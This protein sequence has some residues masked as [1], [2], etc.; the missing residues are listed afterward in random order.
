MLRRVLMS[1][2]VA[3]EVKVLLWA[4]HSQNV[5]A[6]TLGISQ[7]SV[8]NVKA[9]RKFPET[10]WPNGETGPMPEAA[11]N[12]LA[13]NKLKSTNPLM[14]AAMP[15]LT[16][17]AKIV[18]RARQYMETN[19]QD[20]PEWGLDEW[21]EQVHRTDAKDAEVLAAAKLRDDEEDRLVALAARN[22]REKEIA[23]HKVWRESPAGQAQLKLDSEEEHLKRLAMAKPQPMC[24]WVYILDG[25][26][27]LPGV[28]DAEV[29]EDMF[30]RQAIQEQVFSI[31][32]AYEKQDLTHDMR[33]L[34]S[35]GAMTKQRKDR[36]ILLEWASEQG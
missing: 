11:L 19:G 22:A 32:A 21:I 17:D 3:K 6:E 12:V 26:Y 36:A 10:L 2:E 31:E 4:G 5:I 1:H 35:N 20:M 29:Q 28:A 23:A 24:E 25:F 16:G 9:G 15:E 14:Q 7:G 27:E 18:A 13:I 34:L 33:E 8:S 30:M